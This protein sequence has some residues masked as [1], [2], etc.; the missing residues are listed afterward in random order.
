MAYQILRYIVSG[1]IIIGSIRFFIFFMKT[2]Y[3]CLNQ[4]FPWEDEESD[5]DSTNNGS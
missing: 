5:T 2:A 1:V 3:K 4:M